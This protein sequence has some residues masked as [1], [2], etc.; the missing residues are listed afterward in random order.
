MTDLAIAAQPDGTFDLVLFGGDLLAD[1]SLRVAVACSLLT[2]REWAESPDG[3]RRGTWQDALLDDP[4]DRAGSWLWRLAPRK[5]QPAMLSEAKQY[6]EQAL[7]WLV[8]DGIASRVDVVARFD[9]RYELQLDIAIHRPTGLQ[10][11]RLAALWQQSLGP[12]AVDQAAQYVAQLG[13]LVAAFEFIYYV[14][15]PEAML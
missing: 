9:A 13:D 5:R 3:D 14:A 15:Y 2:D 7:A 4:R 8:Q 6:A 10:R 11:F 12:S 1:D